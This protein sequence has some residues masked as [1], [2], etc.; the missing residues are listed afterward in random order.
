MV[1][2]DFFDGA[3]SE[4][5]NEMEDVDNESIVKGHG[6]SISCEM[7]GRSWRVAVVLQLSVLVAC[8][9]NRNEDVSVA[10]IT[11]VG[12]AIEY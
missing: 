6:C 8:L 1:W 7:D 12:R 4:P 10:R 3:T 2:N 9:E 5:G 11:W